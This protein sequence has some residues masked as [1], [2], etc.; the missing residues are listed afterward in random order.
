MPG[1]LQKSHHSCM[2]QVHADRCSA[3]T[4][5]CNPDAQ[6]GEECSVIVT[7]GR[8]REGQL[9]TGARADCAHPRRVDVLR[10]RHVL[11]VTT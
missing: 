7:W 10:S 9:G 2:R 3:Q 5:G 4:L 11:Q 8:G 6:E 1:Y